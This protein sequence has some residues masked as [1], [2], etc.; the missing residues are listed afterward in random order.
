MNQTLSPTT[1]FTSGV[2]AMHGRRSAASGLWHGFARFGQFI[3]NGS[4][5][6]GQ[7][8]GIGIP[9]CSYGGQWWANDEGSFG[10]GIFI[11]PARKLVMASNA[12]WGHNATDPT[13]N[14]AREAF[15]RGVQ[16]AG[17]VAAGQPKKPFCK[18]MC[19][20]CNLYR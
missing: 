8:T 10:Q 15:D 13:A 18:G 7:P 19:R 6:K 11:D 4:Q 5:I 1:V 9:G 20:L 2:K 3:L 17:V 14:A 16:Q 12:N